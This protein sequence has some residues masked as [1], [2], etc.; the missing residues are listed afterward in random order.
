M[1]AWRA[2]GVAIDVSDIIIV[3]C[4]RVGSRLALMLSEH[5]NNVCVIDRDPSAF[6]ALG[7]DF[8]GSTFVGVGYDEEILVNAGIEECDF[9]AAVTQSDNANLMVV[10]IARRLYDVPHAVARLYDS[11]HERTYLQLG[12]D[13]VCGTSLVAEDVFSKIVSGHGSHIDT[14]GEFEVLRFTLD[15]SSRDNAKTIR[16]SELERDHEVRIIAF[17][18][19]DGSASSIPTPD[20]LLYAGDSILACVRHD[21]IAQFSRYILD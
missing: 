3:G 8:N 4:G 21:V 10:E 12:I 14:F 7:R 5:D 20:S 6:A 15:L 2:W 13:Y 9:V 17:E 18:R 19:A 11:S 16:V 1:E